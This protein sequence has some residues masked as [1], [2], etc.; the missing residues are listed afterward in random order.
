MEGRRCDRIFRPVKT[1]QLKYRNLHPT[2]E[3][4]SQKC[5]FHKFQTLEEYY[6][7]NM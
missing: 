3:L 1:A 6:T 2:V 4:I 7:V 5:L